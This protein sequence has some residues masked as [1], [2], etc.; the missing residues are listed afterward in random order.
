VH[1]GYCCL[2]LRTNKNGTVPQHYSGDILES[3]V[4]TTPLGLA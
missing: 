4:V 1:S 3:D 2:E